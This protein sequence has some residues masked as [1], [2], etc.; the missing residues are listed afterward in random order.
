[1]SGTTEI[2]NCCIKSS[3]NTAIHVISNNGIQNT[4]LELNSCVMD[5]KNI[6]ERILGFEGYRPVISVKNCYV[7]NAI[8]FCVV[9]APES[10]CTI[11]MTVMNS[12][13]INVQDGIKI[14]VNHESLVPP[15]T[16]IRGCHF[17]LAA[18]R[19]ND[20]SPSIAFCQTG[21]C[22]ILENNYINMLEHTVPTTGF[23]LHSL[24]LAQ[25]TMNKI[26][27]SEK[28]RLYSV[29]KGILITECEKTEIKSIEIEGMRV[30][31]KFA[32]KIDDEIN[33]AKIENCS[34]KCCSLGLLISKSSDYGENMKRKSNKCKLPLG[35]KMKL[36]NEIKGDTENG[37]ILVSNPTKLSEIMSKQMEDYNEA[38]IYLKMTGCLL[39]TLYYGV[40]NETPKGQM[41]LAENIFQNVPKSVILNH[42]CLD[43]Y[44][45]ELFSN[46]FRLTNMFNYSDI[47]FHDSKQVESL[48]RAMYIHFTLHEN[49]PCRI[50]YEGKDYF[51]VSSKFDE[52]FLFE[53]NLASSVV[54]SDED[55]SQED[56]KDESNYK[57]MI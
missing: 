20:G 52:S 40:M 35:P 44:Q 8:S 7:T 13:F 18:Y 30:G 9:Y 33:S 22:A 39:D 32:N 6:C 55:Q 28:S 5:G 57:G 23:S 47:D 53:N 43:T 19:T 54:V 29:S 38:N 45:L 14:I 15:K 21:G 49:I 10:K 27:S 37:N 1:M 41:C 26:T 36:Q 16:I 4:L 42:D 2:V 34:I 3:A 24:R 51:V 31:L 11:E 46:D 25:L 48:R 17:E 50:A 56:E 12:L